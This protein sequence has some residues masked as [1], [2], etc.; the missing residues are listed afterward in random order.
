MR[1]ARPPLVDAWIA[2]GL[3][4]LALA[5]ILAGVFDAAATETVP[6]ALLLTIPLA[7][8]RRAPA[9]VAV[10]VVSGIALRGLLGVDANEGITETIALVLA[11]YSLAFHDDLVRAAAGL[12]A[13]AALVWISVSASD[14]TGTSDYVFAGLLLAAPWIAGRVI[15]GIQGRAQ[16][17]ERRADEAVREQQAQ[18][19][20][21]VAEERQRI[22][23]ELHDVIA[24][25]ITVMLMNTGATRRLLKPE[26]ERERDGLLTVET[27]GRNALAEMRRLVS[28][29]RRPEEPA[30]LGPQPSLG[31]L[32][33]L[34]DEIRRLGVQVV[35]HTSAYDPNL[36][37][38]LDLAAYRIIQESLT[39]VVK[40]AGA[41]RATV[42]V[43]S[44][45]E[46][47]AITVVDD[48]RSAPP[49]NSFGHGLV[50]MRQRAAI[51]GGS[52]EAGPLPGGGF[53]V[54]AYLP[55]EE[56]NG[57]DPRPHR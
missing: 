5:E 10:A 25:S 47:L 31:Q 49:P 3:L 23:R 56:N 48:G 8:R 13:C 38:G 37:P 18:A 51:Y 45:R 41:T 22:A 4:V 54:H 19:A 53:R 46:G 6:T 2:F 12:A 36:P 57:S 16:A 35:L 11:L 55:L 21:A 17:A 40:H 29:L 24:H 14:G 30:A 32:D 52:L 42:T 39:N 20:A 15:L 1:N 34:G 27:T 33:A 7:W 50:G 26:Q 44:S 9:P 28:M 43:A